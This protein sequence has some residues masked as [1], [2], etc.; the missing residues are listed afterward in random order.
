VSALAVRATA[1]CVLQIAELSVS[2]QQQRWEGELHLELA[3]APSCER[4]EIVLPP[5]AV[6]VKRKVRQRLGDGSGAR[7]GEERWEQGPWGLQGVSLLALHTPELLQ[8]DRV[9]VD[10]ELELPLAPLSCRPGAAKFVAL[11][12]RGQERV[13]Q[14]E[15]AP[16]LALTA[17]PLGPQAPEQ[18]PELLPAGQVRVERQM[19]LKVP[20]GDPQVQLYPGGGSSVAVA[21]RLLFPPSERVRAWPLSSPPGVP[22]QLRTEPEQMARLLEVGATQVLVVESSEG[23][24]RATVSWEEP[25][26]PT[27]GERSP[28]WEALAVQVEA[29]QIDWDGEVWA[30]AEVNGR[31]VLPGREVLVRALDHRFR[32]RA[33]PEPGAPLELRGQPPSWEVAAALR[34]ALHAR[35]SPGDWPH[36][37][38]WPR[39]LSRARRSGALTP[40]E[41]ALVLWLYARQVQLDA[42]WVLVRPAPLGPGSAQ[43]PSG[44]EAALVRVVH[45]GETRWI[46]PV[47][48]ACAPFE[49]PP[50]LEGARALGS[51][52]QL[53]PPPSRGRH[54]VVVGDGTVSWRLEGPAA[55]QMRRALGALPPDARAGALASWMGGPG[56]KLVTLSGLEL[57]GEP[58]E[59]EATQGEGLR[60]D[61]LN[62]SPAMPSGTVWFDWIGERMVRWPA[63][64]GLS[65]GLG[66]PEVQL[67]GEGLSYTRTREEGAMVERLVVEAR[68]VEAALVAQVEAARRAALEAPEAP[69][70][71]SPPEPVPSPP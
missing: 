20:P 1:G 19:I 24:V 7:L 58:I 38:L 43:I 4:T 65:E 23:P 34:P 11:D 52:V 6:L 22:V 31:Q 2:E 68:E 48:T 59:A 66:L 12:V 29:G 25:D 3:A 21:E 18:A 57:A 36:D 17:T 14:S 45:E 46:D 49:L 9:V 28:E 55:L 67:Q 62:S 15:P 50:E 51:D 54:E 64:A 16:D 26:A 37:P 60:V 69:A 44:Y 63:D 10:L 27:Y 32:D 47:C 61:P 71:V 13:W 70:P 8:G 35:I 40:T 53:T 41:A 33:L 56:A 30:L 39:K 5:G 42:S